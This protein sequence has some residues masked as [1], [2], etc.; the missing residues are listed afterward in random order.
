MSHYQERMQRDL[1]EIHDR[2]AALGARV[3][4]AAQAA[5]AALLHRDDRAAARIVLADNPINRETREVDRLCHAF[6]A[7]HLP[8]AGVLRTISSTLRM[9]ITIERVGDYAVTLARETAQLCGEV[10][11]AIAADLRL[12]ADTELSLFA[13]AMQAWNE[14]DASLARGTKAKSSGRKRLSH[15]VFHDLVDV[16]N[17]ASPPLSDLFALLLCINRL[18]RIGSQAKNICEETIFA[19]TGETKQPKSYRILFLDRANDAAS[20]MAEAIARRTFPESG[21]YASAGFQPAEQ[22]LAHVL[23]FLERTGHDPSDAP[24]TFESTYAKI[25]PLHVIVGLDCDASAHIPEL[26]FH[27]TVVRWDVAPTSDEAH[28]MQGDGWLAFVHR[29][30]G[31]RIAD[32]MTTLRGEK[33]G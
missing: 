5:V 24:R 16:G 1:D 3:H 21:H 22:V 20:I 28:D 11:A 23:E 17:E 7:R 19:A 10:P 31:A 32:L 13:R 26:P 12:V 2:V 6:V 14:H 18:E 29:E 25:E 9:T 4:A 33:A 30:L 15:K 8:S 27:T